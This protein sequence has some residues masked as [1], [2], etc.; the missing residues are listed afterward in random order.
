MN[1]LKYIL[2]L[3]FWVLILLL[4]LIP[5]MAQAQ[6]PH[7]ELSHP[8]VTGR[9]VSVNVELQGLFDDESLASL[10]SGVPATLI[11]QWVVRLERDGWHDPEVARG[12][13]RNRVFFDVLEEEYFLF[14]HLGRPLGACSALAGVEEILCNQDSLELGEIPGLEKD[15]RYYIEMLVSLIILSNEEVRGF[16]N[17]LMGVDGGSNDGEDMGA[18]G[19]SEDSSGTTSGLSEMVLGLVKKIAGISDPSVK[20]RSPSFSGDADRD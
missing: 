4:M 1:I 20:G 14:N 9:G 16:E 3:L 18:S 19:V 17:W 15:H 13:V 12:E 5:R 10:Q 6:T 7:L 11:F 8:R 2:L